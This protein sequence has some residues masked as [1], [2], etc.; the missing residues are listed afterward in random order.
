M[1]RSEMGDEY[2]T[3]SNDKSRVSRDGKDIGEWT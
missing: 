3:G 1:P 2:G